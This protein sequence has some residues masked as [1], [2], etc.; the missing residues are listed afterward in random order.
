V[1]GR[2]LREE[3]GGWRGLGGFAVV[4]VHI[5]IANVV[6]LHATDHTTL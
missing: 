1:V 2:W 6:G 5:Q 4:Q 3:D